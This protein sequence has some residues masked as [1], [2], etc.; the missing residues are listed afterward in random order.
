MH[1]LMAVDEVGQAAEAST[2]AFSCA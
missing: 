2:K 1:V